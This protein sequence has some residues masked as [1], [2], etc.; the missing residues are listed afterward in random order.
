MKIWEKGYQLDQV[1]ETFMT[2][3]DPLLDHALI[4]YDCLGSMAHAKMLKK[5]GILTGEE[6]DQLV[7]ELGSLI[8]LTDEG[9]F[10]ILPED[11]DVHTA[12][13]NAL[14]VKL[15]DIGKK[16]HTARSRNDQILL[17]MRLYMKNQILQITTDVLKACET[18]CQFA[19]L[20]QQ[21]PIPGRTHFQRAMP[22]SLG[23][24]A[25]AFAE[26]LLDDLHLLE[27]SYE[28]I[29]Q[30][31]LGSAASYGV[32]LPIDRKYCADLLGFKAVQNNVLYANNSRGKFEASV[33]HVLV[34]I[35]ND[36]SKVATDII[37]FSAPEFGYFALP[38]KFCPGS[39]LMP[40]KRNPCP[41]EIIRAKSAVLQGLLFQTLEIVRALPS[42]YNR[43]FQ[44]TKRPIMQ[45]LEITGM[46]LKVFS[47]IFSELEVNEKRC[48]EAFTPE[49]FA[50][51]QVL[52]LTL[53]GIPFRDAYKQVAKDPNNV[54]ETDPVANILSKR[55]QGATGNLG[56]ELIYS[57]LNDYRKWAEAESEKWKDSLNKLLPHAQICCYGK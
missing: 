5:I 57:R 52:K 25:G 3:D 17:D 24:W 54:S 40:Q 19:E 10:K 35:M 50:T 23:L 38:E 7:Q 34:Q 47:Q 21:V 22:S 29:N 51:D 56:I 4:T 41:L 28:L 30:C 33:L 46:S 27:G 37:I 2:G 53:G 32:S 8:Q 48:R 13:E 6:C 14:V 9:K 49:L 18:L 1:I 12:V 11:E 39:S 15:G 44:E 20:H 45:G 16:L 31:P 36:L 43:D 26:S 55:H 42:G